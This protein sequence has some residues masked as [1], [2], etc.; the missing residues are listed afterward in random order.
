MKPPEPADRPRTGR[1]LFLIAAL[2]YLVFVIYGSLVPLEYR[3]VSWEEAVERFRHIPFLNLGIGSR[4]DW[5]AN[6]L[7]FIP[8]AYLALAALWPRQSTAARIII[9]ALLWPVLVGLAFAIEF[10]QIFFP[11]RTV[12]QNDILAESLGGLVGI[13]LWWWNG[14]AVSRWLAAWRTARGPASVA[15][16]LLVAYLVVLF[17]YSLL[18]LD[19]T[20]SPVEVYHKWQEGKVVLVP[21]SGYPGGTAEWLYEVATDIALWIPVS[22]LWAVSGRRSRLGAWRWAVLAALILE[23]LQLLVY[24]RVT[25]ISDILTA[26]VGAGIGVWLVPAKGRPQTRA[27][28]HEGRGGLVWLGMAVFSLG[29]LVMLAVFWYPYDFVLERSFLR[30]RIQLLYQVPFRAYYYGTEFRAVTSLIQ[31]L[32]F[33]APLGAGLA[34]MVTPLRDRALR[35]TFHLVAVAVLAGVAMV[36]ELGQVALPGKNADSTDWALE[37]IGGMAGYAVTLWAVARSRGGARGS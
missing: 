36:A 20:I 12:S 24:S 7:L 32:A 1:S 17:G 31:R 27:R 4:A 5:V 18:P 15:E 10:T 21:F 3:P 22:L 28:N 11:Q 13:G 9:S 8:L 33:F 2:G 26:M 23:G 25:D 19:L 14:A 35:W 29:T 30:E 37:L 6:L 16:R 34:L